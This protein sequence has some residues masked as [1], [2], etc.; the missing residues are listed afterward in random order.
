[1]PLSKDRLVGE[2]P[3]FSGF[4]AERVFKLFF[5]SS[6]VV[7]KAGCP[8]KFH[9]MEL[10]GSYFLPTRISFHVLQKDNFRKKLSRT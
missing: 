10:M 7:S 5:L 6:Y 8:A 9:Q 4:G 3:S 1:M 2:M